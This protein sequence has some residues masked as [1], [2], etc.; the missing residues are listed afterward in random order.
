[1]SNRIPKK[2]FLIHVQSVGRFQMLQF[3]RILPQKNLFG[4]TR[5]LMEG[6]IFQMV[7]Q[8]EIQGEYFIQHRVLFHL[9]AQYII[10]ER[11]D[12]IGLIKK[13]GLNTRTLFI[14]II[15]RFHS[16]PSK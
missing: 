15:I 9:L 3:G 16:K 11:A 5:Y 13:R 12:I 14:L 8:K 4:V 7:Q 1:M 10:L 6:T 2:V